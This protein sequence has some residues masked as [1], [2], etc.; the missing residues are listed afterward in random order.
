[1]RYVLPFGLEVNSCDFDEVGKIVFGCRRLWMAMRRI[2]DLARNS[3]VAARSEALGFRSAQQ[4]SLRQ[5]G[6]C[7][8]G[9]PSP[10]RRAT[11]AIVQSPPRRRLFGFFGSNNA[12]CAANSSSSASPFI[13]TKNISAISWA[14]KSSGIIWALGICKWLFRRLPARAKSPEFVVNINGT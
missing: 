6:E 12:L 9:K 13:S 14:S 7:G 10:R 3:G 1:M 2:W 8:A 5:R 4:Q 11:T